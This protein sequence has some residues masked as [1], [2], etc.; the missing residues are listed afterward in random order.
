MYFDVIDN[1]DN[2][3]EEHNNIIDKGK[4]GK[5]SISGFEFD[6]TKTLNT[7]YMVDR[8]VTPTKIV[9]WHL[10]ICGLK[11]KIINNGRTFLRKDNCLARTNSAMIGNN[12]GISDIY[13][14]RWK[15]DKLGMSGFN[16]FG[17]CTH[18]YKDDCKEAQSWMNTSIYIGW[19][20][21]GSECNEKHALNALVCGL[22]KKELVKNYN[23]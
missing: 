3:E 23:V 22:G 1:D 8:L 12:S 19:A 20:T 11:N 21:G 5:I 17:I 10:D 6:I 4:T 18:D 15:I 2:D 9:D 14:I 7:H 13:Q 16:G